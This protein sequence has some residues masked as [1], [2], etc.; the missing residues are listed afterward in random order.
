MFRSSTHTVRLPVLTSV[1]LPHLSLA[2]IASLLGIITVVQLVL[3][4]AVILQP[5]EVMYV[6]AVVYDQAARLL[7]GEPLYQPLDRPPYTVA[8][9]T[10]VYYS[11]AA[12]LQAVVGPGFGPGRSLSFVAGFAS[13]IV[14][15]YLATSRS[16]D[17]WAGAFAALLF[18]ALGLP[19]LYLWSALY[20]VDLLG[21][22]LSLGA[23]ATL[24]GGTTRRRVLLG[25]LLAGLAIL[26]K[27]TF[28]AAALAGTVWLWQRDHKQAVVFVSASLLIVSGVCVVM[29]MTTGAFFA[30]T[31]F[32][33]ANPFQ[34]DALLLNMGIFVFF[35]GGPLAVAG[36]YLLTGRRS[37]Q[38]QDK[39]LACYF[40]A[41]LLPLLG[42]G[43]IG[44][45]QNYWIECAAITAVLATLGIWSRL[46]GGA[47]NDRHGGAF[48]PLSLIGVT[49]GFV[50]L[51]LSSS[52]LPAWSEV[53]PNAAYAAEFR[54]LVERVQA[55]PREVLAEPLDVVVL[56]GRRTLFEPT[57]FGILNGQGLWDAAPLYRD[58]CAGRVGLL[59]LSEPLGSEL[60]QRR[61]YAYWP[62]T[63][64]VALQDTMVLEA[65]QAGR[66]V[67][68]AGQRAPNR[69][70]DLATS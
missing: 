44:S 6:E 35:Q 28:I 7:R 63:I 20:R 41:S 68:V 60:Q 46:Q 69:G 47:E 31:V 13:A 62:A 14:L 37:I 65:T 48:R 26:T 24:F 5:R 53:A 23:V 42:L 56:A 1:T 8:A 30:N 54:K 12:G 58:I 2:I 11:L 25:G 33:N 17:R 52:A 34:V 36:L 50:T 70:C 32:A 45:D 57:I 38:N 3:S 21:V 39:L 9:Y 18:L 43:K 10:P 19:W 40:V 51:S 22:A 64:L 59:V 15:A 16:G 29:E 4:I 61:G 66:F 67:Y 55:E 49:V 27:Q